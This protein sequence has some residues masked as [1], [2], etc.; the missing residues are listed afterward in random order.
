MAIENIGNSNPNELKLNNHS[1]DFLRETA[2][3]AHFLSIIGFIGIGII[4]IVA[5]FFSSFMASAYS[6]F[7]GAASSG[8][9]LTI[10]Y[11]LVAVLY[12]FPVLYLYKFSSN[13]KRALAMEDEVTL[14]KSFENL[15]SHYK[16]IGILTI[17][18][19]SFYILIFV[20]GLAA[21]LSSL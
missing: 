13:M 18:M 17:V 21:G 5:I 16:F 10:I 4:V 19:L 7:P 11:I 3:W 9:F 1:K 8:A 2:K 6:E 14:A 12:F 20:I 15:K